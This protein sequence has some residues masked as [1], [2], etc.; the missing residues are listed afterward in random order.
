MGNE[1]HEVDVASQSAI[2][3]D[4]KHI[5]FESDKVFKDLCYD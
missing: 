1:S 2:F 4:M 3:E 5:L